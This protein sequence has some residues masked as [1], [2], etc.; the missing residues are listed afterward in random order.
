MS[1]TDSDGGTTFHDAA[2]MAASSPFLKMAPI[3]PPAQP[4]APSWPAHPLSADGNSV[5]EVEAILTEAANNID[6]A[7]VA[8]ISLRLQMLQ[9]RQL[10][11]VWISSR[12]WRILCLISLVLLPPPHTSCNTKLPS[13]SR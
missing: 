11:W 12:R 3:V 13:A 8:L 1:L 10:L 7:V 5:D 6:P 9:L 2:A 4:S